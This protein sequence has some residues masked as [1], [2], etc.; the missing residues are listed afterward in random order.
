MPKV[1]PGETRK[2]Y[3]S[4]AIPYMIEKE[5]LTPVQAAGKAHGMYDQARKRR[6]RG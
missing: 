5:G 3:V 6:K 2:K 4:R 1:K